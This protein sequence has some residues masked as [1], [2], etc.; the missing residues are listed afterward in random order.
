MIY[1]KDIYL[2]A[3]NK[4][5][6]IKFTCHDESDSFISKYYEI[7]EVSLG[8]FCLDEINQDLQT[9][10]CDYSSIAKDETLGDLINLLNIVNKGADT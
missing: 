2:D 10:V 1:D 6:D 7:W 4:Y 5:T 3:L 8:L 9:G